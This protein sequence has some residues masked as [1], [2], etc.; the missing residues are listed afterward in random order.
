M[1]HR[2]ARGRRFVAGVAVT[3][4]DL[5]TAFADLANKLESQRAG[6]RMVDSAET[7]HAR[8]VFDHFRDETVSKIREILNDHMEDS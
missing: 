8:L 5:A 3:A 4:A 2:G 7:R 1:G 6:H